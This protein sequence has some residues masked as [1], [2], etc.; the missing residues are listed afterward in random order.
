MFEFLDISF[1]VLTQTKGLAF[2]FGGA[3]IFSLFLWIAS[4]VPF[5]L[6]F[7]GVPIFLALTIWGYS[8]VDDMLGYPYWGI[9]TEQAVLLGYDVQ[10]KG[11]QL[12]II[13]WVREKESSRLYA[14]PWSM[15]KEEQLRKA[16]QGAKKGKRYAIKRVEPG[17]EAIQGAAEGKRKGEVFREGEFMLYEFEDFLYPDKENT[18]E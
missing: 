15:K 8:E 9:P 6:R 10:P 1:Q 11:D 12:E 16:M 2:L 14:T 18:G 17:E 5:W 4:R 3:I 7:L 13:L